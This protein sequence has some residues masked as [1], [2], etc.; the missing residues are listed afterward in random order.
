[1]NLCLVSFRGKG[2]P[3]G[4]FDRFIEGQGTGAGARAGVDGKLRVMKGRA[5]EAG[6]PLSRAEQSVYTPRRVNLATNR[7]RKRRI[8]AKFS[9]LS[10]S[11]FLET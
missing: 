6:V 10:S 3:A 2:K 8:S 5:C 7:K 4:V 11:A 1:M 9:K